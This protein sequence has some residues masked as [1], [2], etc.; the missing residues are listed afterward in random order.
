MRHLN[1]T[2][3]LGKSSPHRKA[4]LRNLATA[5]FRE[6]RIHTT[7]P[8]AKVLRSYAEK[9][10]TLGKR[11]DLASR[12][13]AARDVRDHAVLQKLFGE[14]AERFRERI[15]GYTRVLH[16][17]FRRGD[18]AA[19]SLIELVDYKPRVAEEPVKEG[20]PAKEGKAAKGAKATEAK[21]ENEANPAKKVKAVAEGDE[22]KPAAKRKKT[23]KEAKD[24]IK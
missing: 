3:K 4:M 19:V 22:A 23:T 18:A 16:V 20:K 24:E 14:I 17:G 13:L 5:L 9:L 6:E 11:G 15:G 2:K 1:G 10:I 7:T 12:R 8:R 21:A